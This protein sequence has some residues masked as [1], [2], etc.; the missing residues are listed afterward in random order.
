MTLRNISSF[1]KFRCLTT[2]LQIGRARKNIYFQQIRGFLLHDALYFSFWAQRAM[3]GVDVWIVAQQSLRF[4]N[5]IIVY[6]YKMKRLLPRHPNIISHET[7]V[8]TLFKI[9]IFKY[10]VVYLLL[11]ENWEHMDDQETSI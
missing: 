5:V 3:L 6:I 8:N 9:Y 11:I 10:K 2:T 7:F 4:A 1:W